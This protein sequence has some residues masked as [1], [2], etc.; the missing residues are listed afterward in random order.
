MSGLNQ[1]V[2]NISMRLQPIFHD[3]HRYNVEKKQGKSF[4]GRSNPAASSNPPRN[5]VGSS[6]GSSGGG[7]NAGSRSSHAPASSSGGSQGNPSGQRPRPGANFAPPN[8]PSSSRNSSGG[9]NFAGGRSAFM[10]QQQNR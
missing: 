3:N 4:G 8:N 10:Q 9:S 6:S 2:T 1:A 7:S 5:S